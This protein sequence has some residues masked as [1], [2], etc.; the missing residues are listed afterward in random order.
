MAAHSPTPPDSPSNAP[1]ATL[2]T[3]PAGKTRPL[4]TIIL[5]LAV[6]AGA[7][8]LILGV[9]RVTPKIREHQTAVD[10]LTRAKQHT[11]TLRDE[12]TS[13]ATSVRELRAALALRR[14]R[15]AYLLRAQAD[16]FASANSLGSQSGTYAG[17]AAGTRAGTRGAHTQRSSVNSQGWYYLR[18]SWRN[19]LPVIA[20]SYT[21][22]PGP[23]HAYSVE[24]GKAVNRDTSG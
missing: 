16:G 11:Q 24:G 18:V 23:E 12:L 5:G 17:A 10:R 15:V 22:D 9:T 19:G 20:D 2:E 8:T 7:A 4:K 6:M 3:A 21:V 13:H 1:E 14:A